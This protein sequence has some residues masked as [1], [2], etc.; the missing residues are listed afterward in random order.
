M[1]SIQQPVLETRLKVTNLT[2][3]T[4]LATC[5]EVADSGPKRNK[6]LLGRKALAAGGGLWIIPCESVHTFFMQFSIDLVYLDRKN[7][8][9]KVCD[10]VLPWRLSACLTAH[11]ILELPSGT[12][13]NTRTK[14]G[15]T[16]EFAPAN[17]TPHQADVASA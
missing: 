5:L 14:P 11:S 9:R 17:G 12:I 6:G 10:S 1:N 13:R 3:G 8:V 15:D 2:R 16:L 7:T 4:V